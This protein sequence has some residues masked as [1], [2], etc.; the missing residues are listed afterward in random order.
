MIEARGLVKRYGST[1]AVNDLSFTAYGVLFLVPR[2]A[3]ALPGAWYADVVRWRPGGEVINAITG[4]P[5]RQQP[6]PVLR[7][8]RVRGVRR[9]HRGRPGNWRCAVPQP[10]RLALGSGWPSDNDNRRVIAAPKYLD[11]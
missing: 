2:L 8:R 6:G 3:E 9:L 4:Y 7:V 1:L 10:G 5:E 11:S